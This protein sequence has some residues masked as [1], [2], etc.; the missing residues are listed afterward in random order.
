MEP[1]RE[2]TTV[3][4]IVF[5]LSL[6]GAGT[7]VAETIESHDETISASSD[8]VLCEGQDCDGPSASAT[9]T[10]STPDIHPSEPNLACIDAKENEASSEDCDV[11]EPEIGSLWVSVHAGVDGLDLDYNS[12]EDDPV[13][14]SNAAPGSNTEDGFL[15]N[16]GAGL[17]LVGAVGA[18]G[19]AA[20]VGLRRFVTL[21]L[22]PLAS[23]LQRS[24]LLENDKRRAIYEKISEDPGINLRALADELDLAWGTLLHHLRKLEDNHLVTSQRYG[25]YRRFFLNGST[26]NEEEQARL[27]ALS[28]PSTARV[29]EYILDNPGASQSEIGDAIGVTASTIL[30]H[31][32]R[33]KD[34]ELVEEERDGRYVHY[35]PKIS[36]HEAQQMAAA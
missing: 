16:Y 13:E 22:A 23:R 8:D 11:L 32:R 26:Y 3:L 34:V 4:V 2:T 17:L 9:T 10:V 19:M 7:A 35:Y 21:L 24:E 27:A 6:F 28:T 25:K 12:E 29:A 15:E 20:S 1:L 30:F 33:L 18:S 14:E 36:D 31:V 5:A